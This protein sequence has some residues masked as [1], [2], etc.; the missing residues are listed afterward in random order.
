MMIRVS[1][2]IRSLSSNRVSST[3]MF[4]ND[5][6][7]AA[8]TPVGLRSSHCPLLMHLATSCRVASCHF[9]QGCIL[10]LHAGLHLAT[11]CRVASC[12]FMQGCILPLHAGLHL[13]TSCRVASCH[14][15]QGCILPLHAGL[16]LATSCRV[17]SSKVA[18]FI[19]SK[20][21]TLDTA[22]EVDIQISCVFLLV[23]WQGCWL[24][25]C[26]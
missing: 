15:M 21:I 12:H 11:S 4:L 19:S 10:P 22:Y 20:R 8:S 25:A 18:H 1:Q 23:F 24:L 14:F 5:D 7:A 9:M 16:H 26:I 13:A 2:R 3:W 17:A 6:R